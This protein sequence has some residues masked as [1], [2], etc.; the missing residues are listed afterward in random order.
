MFGGMDGQAGGMPNFEEQQKAVMNQIL[1]DPEVQ[2]SEK[3]T[4]IFGEARENPN[5][6]MQHMSDPEVSAF[7]QKYASKMFGD[8]NPFSSMFGGSG[9]RN[10]DDKHDDGNMYA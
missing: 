3:L 4:R 7:M 10:D 1:E 6:L 9:P 5:V 8:N 2:Q